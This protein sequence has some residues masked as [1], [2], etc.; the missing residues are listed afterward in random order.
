MKKGNYIQEA[1][2]A[3]KAIRFM[4]QALDDG[5]PSSTIIVIDTHADTFSGFLQQTGGSSSG[6]S[7]QIGDIL[8]SY[9]PNEFFVC[10]EE[11]SKISRQVHPP[12]LTGDEREP[13]SD[14][15]ISS[16][17]GWR[18]LVVAS[19]GPAMLTATHYP[20]LQR[21]VKE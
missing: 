4:K 16:R 8:T 19:C 3:Q 2:K 21:L 14:M 20:F 13:W 5:T 12:V 17:G 18:C 10:T 1:D 11:A 6:T 15:T 9:L 7:V